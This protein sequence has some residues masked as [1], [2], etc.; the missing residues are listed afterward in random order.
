MSPKNITKKQGVR[1]TSPFYMVSVQFFLESSEELSSTDKAAILVQPKALEQ[2][3]EEQA[4]IEIDDK[5]QVSL[6]SD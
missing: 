6:S 1:I 2:E 5:L 3:V 4:L